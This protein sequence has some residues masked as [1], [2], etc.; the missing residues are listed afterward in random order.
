MDIAEGA[1]ACANENGEYTGPSQE[2]GLC[3]GFCKEI[4]T[5]YGMVVDKSINAMLIFVPAGIIVTYMGCSETVIFIVN[6][7]AMVVRD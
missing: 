6:F 3:R 7:L 1:D 2:R 4:V 5:I